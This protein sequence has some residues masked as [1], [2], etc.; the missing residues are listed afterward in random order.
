MDARLPF[1]NGG[2]SMQYQNDPN[3]FE[4]A[5]PGQYG[6]GLFQ[7]G[8]QDD[9]DDGGNN[10]SGFRFDEPVTPTRQSNIPFKRELNQSPNKTG[11]QIK[12][13]DL[14]QEDISNEPYIG[15]DAVVVIEGEMRQFDGKRLDKIQRYV[16]SLVTGNFMAVKKDINLQIQAADINDKTKQ[17]KSNRE[18]MEKEMKEIQKVWVNRVN[19]LFNM[20]LGLLAGMS[21]M[22]LIVILSQN[23]RGS[24]LQ[25]YSKISTIVN[26]VFMVF[27]SFCLIL[28][29]SLTLIYKQK[30]DEKMRNMDEFRLEFRQH[31]IVSAVMTAIVAF[32]LLLLYILPTFTNKIYYWNP[33]NVSDS[34]ILKCKGLFAAVNVFFIIAWL[35]ASAFNKAS[36]SDLD[37]DPEEMND[38]QNQDDTQD[39]D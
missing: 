18:Q 25:L 11:G 21:A 19:K 7:P 10:E 24:F 22:H 27:T 33:V 3:N 6:G 17:L 13:N 34:D 5:Q 39:S 36:I 12:L 35:M 15:R 14:A 31:Y 26:I 29:L 16:E 1:V 37:M 4:Y 32:C 28:G 8:Q 2:I 9:Y 30:S 20:F 38:D 23:D